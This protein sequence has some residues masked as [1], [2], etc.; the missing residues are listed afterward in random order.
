MVGPWRTFIHLKG[1]GRFGSKTSNVTKLMEVKFFP[2][3]RPKEVGHSLR[4]AKGGWSLPWTSLT[5]SPSALGLTCLLVPC[6]LGLGSLPSPSS[7]G[8]VCLPELYY[9]EFD[10]LPSLKALDLA[11]LP[12]PHY[13]ISLDKPR[14]DGHSLGCSKGECAF[15]WACHRLGSVPRAWHTAKPKNVQVV[16]RIR[17]IVLGF[18]ILLS[19]ITTVHG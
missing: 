9:L 17:R 8:L 12:N 13:L 15:L 16:A 7:L 2:E 1:I 6:C 3:V 19:P 18:G 4:R 14:K 5:T 11:F 10:W